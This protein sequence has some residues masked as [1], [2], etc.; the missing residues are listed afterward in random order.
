MGKSKGTEQ[1]KAAK[2]PDEQKI[3]N[4]LGMAKRAGKLAVGCMA[5]EKAVAVNKVQGVLIAKDAAGA[6][7]KN[8]A[9]KIEAA[10]IPLRVV[11][12]GSRMGQALGSDNDIVAVAVLDKGFW[13]EIEK[14]C[15]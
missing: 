7:T 4:M 2:T 1:P 11:L 10:G 13:R 3:A 5:A 15:E 12:T 6:T 9:K 14:Q 8:C